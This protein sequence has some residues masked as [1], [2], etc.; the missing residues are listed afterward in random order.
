MNKNICATALAQLV[1]L[2]LFRTSMRFESCLCLAPFKR[3]LVWIKHIYLC[4]F[5]AGDWSL[6]DD[7]F[8]YLF[9]FIDLQQH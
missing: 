3:N 2:L 5:F 4:K 7:N 9:Q 6:F 8:F 1:K